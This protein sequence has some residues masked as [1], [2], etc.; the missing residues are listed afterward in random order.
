M[1]EAD[2][3]H[4]EE[5]GTPDIIGC[6]RAGLVFQLKQS[7]GAVEIEKRERAFGQAAI[8]HWKR[9]PS[10][11]LLGNT[12]VPRLSILSFLI[13]HQNMV[14]H[15]NFVV[16]LLNNLFRIQARGGCSCAG[17]YGSELLHIDE[18]LLDQLAN[19]V[20]A[21]H[22]GIKPG[23]TRINFNYFISATT[24]RFILHA[25]DF[26]ATRRHVFL[27]Q[28]RF[29]NKTGLWEHRNSR[30]VRGLGNPLVRHLSSPGGGHVGEKVF[31]KYLE[32]ARELAILAEK[33]A[34]E[35]FIPALPAEVE[36]LRWFA[37]P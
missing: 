35:E 28:Y 14:L 32:R 30:P 31:T 12:D 18:P 33:A 26:V 29:D 2:I 25:V 9:H 1:Y 4:R 27:W 5:G 17:P 24:F 3:E 8:A 13:R 37:L 22:A 21:G 20:V 6:I 11:V 10:I 36:E 23:W 34:G 15:H 16:V 19:A 7:I